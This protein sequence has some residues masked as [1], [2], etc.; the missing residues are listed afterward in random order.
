M[1]MARQLVKRGGAA[2]FFSRTYIAEDLE[3]KD[4]TQVKVR[5]LAPIQRGS[6]L[7]HRARENPL[8]PAADDLV[9]VIEHQATKLG[10]VVSRE[11]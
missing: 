8:S 11:R 2:G 5:D 1:E 4:L 10:M 9:V 3:K 6:A 7:V